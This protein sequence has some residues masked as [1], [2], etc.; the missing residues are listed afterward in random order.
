M[1]PSLPSFFLLMYIYCEPKAL[2]GT[3]IQ[4]VNK[5]NTDISIITENSIRQCC[6]RPSKVRPLV[7]LGVRP[8]APES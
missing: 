3:E 8:E 5:I 7:I 6:Y 4:V 2:L 1:C